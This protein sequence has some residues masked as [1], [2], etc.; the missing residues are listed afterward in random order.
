MS[1][2]LDAVRFR[3]VTAAQEAGDRSGSPARDEAP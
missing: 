2:A 1:S 3:A